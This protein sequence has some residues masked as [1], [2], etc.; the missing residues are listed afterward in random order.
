MRHETEY[1]NSVIEK[2]QA[3][4]FIP[5]GTM[6]TIANA[7]SKLDRFGSTVHSEMI[8]EP[9]NVFNLKIAGTGEVYFR[10]DI[11]VSVNNQTLDKFQD[12]L[13]HESLSRNIF[14]GEYNSPNITLKFETPSISKMLGPTKFNMIEIDPFLNGSFDITS[15][16]IY[17]YDTNGAYIDTPDTY[18]FPSC[19]KMRFILPEKVSFYKIEMGIKINYQTQKND[20]KLYPFGLKHI[21]FYDADFRPDSY[22]VTI[23]NSEKS[24]GSLNEDIRIKTPAGIIKTTMTEQGIVSYIDY[25]NGVFETPVVTSTE[26][27]LNTIAREINKLY[28]KIPLLGK[29]LIAADFTYSTK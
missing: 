20:I 19:G 22:A 13:K 21:Y 23:I 2:L 14:F 26:N 10:N 25:N 4:M 8:K 16:K 18:T 11:N 24:I 29:S 15:L 28:V 17:K 9:V 27:Q 6:K 3:G 5:D 7:Y 1:A 12:I